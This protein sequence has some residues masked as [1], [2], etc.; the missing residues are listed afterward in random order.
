MLFIP[1][2]L[3]IRDFIEVDGDPAFAPTGAGV[4]RLTIGPDVLVLFAP[5]SPEGVPG[6]A[7]PGAIAS[8]PPSAWWTPL[9]TDYLSTCL[10]PA[11]DTRQ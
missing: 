8:S 9:P 6:F 1:D 4:S 5:P 2:W 7:V 10:L 11:K 3:A